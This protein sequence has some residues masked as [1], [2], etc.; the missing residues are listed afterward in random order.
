MMAPTLTNL[1]ML[2]SAMVVRF[3]TCSSWSALAVEVSNWNS[4]PQTMLPVPACAAVTLW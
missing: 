3:C 1:A 4:A 2:D